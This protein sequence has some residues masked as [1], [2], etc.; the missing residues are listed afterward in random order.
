M[1]VYDV[2]FFKWH[3]LNYTKSDVPNHFSFPNRYL[4]KNNNP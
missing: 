1:L 3:N 2:S 4:Y